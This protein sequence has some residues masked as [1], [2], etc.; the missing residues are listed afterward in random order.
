MNRFLHIIVNQHSRKSTN[1]F[2][3]LLLELPKYTNQ[4][5]IH[6]TNNLEQLDKLLAQLKE[7]ASADDLIVFVGG[8]GSLNHG[9]TLMEKYA[10]SNTIGYIP[11]GSGN[12]F[13]RANGISTNI[14]KAVK[15]FFH[16]AQEKEMAILHATE[17][18]T[19]YYAVNSLGIGI[20]GYVNHLINEKSQ[21]KGL[22]PFLYLKTLVSAFKNQKK[23]SVALK[24]DQGIFTFEDV[25]LALFVN[26]PYFAGGLEIMP[27]A[28]NLDDDLEVMIGHGVTYKDLFNIIGKLLT[29]KS[30]LDHPKIHVFKTK[31]ASIFTEVIEYG[32]KDGEVIFQEG[33]ALTFSTK[34]RLFWL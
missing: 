31:N 29:G 16:T 33:Y 30:H 15:D 3:S 18:D 4:Y 17:G 32:Q 2:K 23:F 7:T 5:D 19:N 25:Q 21:K 28:S 13:A 26:N 12:D 34:K 1:K 27:G 14:A 11:T 6:Q 20:D 10:I 9:V 8:D 24:V 22:G